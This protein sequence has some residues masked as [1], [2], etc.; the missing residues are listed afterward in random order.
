MKRQ[1]INIPYFLLVYYIPKSLT[2]YLQES[3]ITV[4]EVLILIA[5][6]LL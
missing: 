3:R 1:W 6:K 5:R 2:D 4:F